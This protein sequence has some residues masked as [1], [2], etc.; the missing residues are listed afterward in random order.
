[1]EPS[2][3]PENLLGV[4]LSAASQIS[5]L[6]GPNQHMVVPCASQPPLSHDWYSPPLPRLAFPFSPLG[7][8]WPIAQRIVFLSLW[9]STGAI[10]LLAHPVEE[11]VNLPARIAATFHTTNAQRSSVLKSFKSS[12]RWSKVSELMLKQLVGL[13]FI[14]I[15]WRYWFQ[16]VSVQAN[17]RCRRIHQFA[18]LSSGTRAHF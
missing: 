15:G 6:A 4:R 17:P 14:K 16:H 11:D 3:S 18:V 9:V 8:R 12:T 5:V 7:V 1:M 2:S 10:C 13:V